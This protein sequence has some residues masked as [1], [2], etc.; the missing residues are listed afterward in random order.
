MEDTVQSYLAS[1]RLEAKKMMPKNG[2]ILEVKVTFSDSAIKEYYLSYEIKQSQGY[3]S[4]Y[5]QSELLKDL[6]E[7][8][9]NIY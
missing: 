9:G 1:I 3:A 8:L 2:R 4:G 5:T 6:K 7:N